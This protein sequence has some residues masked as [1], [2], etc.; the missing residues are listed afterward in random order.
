[1]SGSPSRVQFAALRALVGIDSVAQ[2]TCSAPFPVGGAAGS[3][4]SAFLPLGSRLIARRAARNALID[5]GSAVVRSWTSTDFTVSWGLA[6]RSLPA[7]SRSFFD[8]GLDQIDEGVNPMVV[9]FLVLSSL[10]T[11]GRSHDLPLPFQREGS[12][13]HAWKT[14]SERGGTISG[15]RCSGALKAR[16]EDISDFLEFSCSM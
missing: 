4:D 14:P 2:D 3:R 1:M 11:C 6:G 15:C 10:G 12:Q 16:V 8:E 13:V 7:E 5:G 9:E